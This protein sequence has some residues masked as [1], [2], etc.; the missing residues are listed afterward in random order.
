MFVHSHCELPDLDC[1]TNPDGVRHYITPEGNRYPSITTILQCLSKKDIDRWK[2][3]VGV[4]EST[5]ISRRAAN[6]GTN[7]HSLIEQYLKNEKINPTIG[8]NIVKK[9]LDRIGVIRAQEVAL[10]SDFYKIAGRTD[11][12]AE[13]DGKLS[14]IDFKTSKGFKKKEWIEGYF[15]QATFYAEAWEERTGETIND[16]V[17]IISGDDGSK[18]V[19]T[20]TKEQYIDLLITVIDMY[21]NEIR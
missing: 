10:W 15:I 9:D 5:S 19:Y 3:R 2:D 8:F 18:M 20:E 17:I 7:L 14:V 16:L 1:V 6:R 4:A 21:A 12:I 13:F 11:C